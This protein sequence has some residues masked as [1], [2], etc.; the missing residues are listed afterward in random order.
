MPRG[1][2]NKS[3]R[4]ANGAGSIRKKTIRRNDKEYTYWEARYTT[5]YDPGTGK[6]I[7]KTITAKTQKEAAQQLREATSQLDIGTY[8][9]P[10]KQTV[11]EWL[12]I[13]MAEYLFGVKPRTASIY[14]NDI[15]HY[16]IPALGAIRLEALNAHT[17]QGF[18]NHL[19]KEGRSVPK[20]DKD[21]HAVRRNGEI[22]YESAPLSPKTI[23][24]IHGVLHRA[25]KQAVL[26]GYLRFNP[27]DACILPRI[28]KS[29]LMPLDEFQISSF[30]KAIKG[31][32]FESLFLVALF[33]G[34]RQG[35]LLGLTWD[36]IN[37]TSGTILVDKQLQLHQ[38]KGVVAYKL[39]STK[40]GR[41]RTITAAPFV[42]AQLKA[43]WKQQAQQKLYAGSAW[44]Q[45]NLVFT[46]E[47]G[48][49]LTKPTVYREYKRI[50]TSI[51]RPDAR[52]HDLRHSYAIAAIRAGDDIKTVQG[53]LGHATAA[54]TL[55]VYG[56]VTDQMKRDSAARMESFIATVSA[57]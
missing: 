9:A 2:T 1:K 28:E 52:F 3:G 37:F 56:H 16:I 11:K 4:G 23:K 20:R 19:A 55:D 44:E 45:S 6:Q 35:E 42:M 27:A 38:E 43:R 12:E 26:N 57:L 25:L 33:T 22:V 24:N 54:F 30:L 5:G 51:G 41:S 10:N 36:C 18:Y 14:T 46:D 7:Q 49:H 15:V 34:M 31:N 32:R 8:I 53:N 13:W 47:A 48:H 39:V 21:G 29:K 50:V 40:N 17:I